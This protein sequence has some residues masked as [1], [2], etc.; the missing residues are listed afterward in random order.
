MSFLKSSQ[1]FSYPFFFL[2]K[3]SSGCFKEQNLDENDYYSL[4]FVPEQGSRM[5]HTIKELEEKLPT[6]TEKCQEFERDVSLFDK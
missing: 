6:A 4:L 1:E 2:N 3:S 5:Q